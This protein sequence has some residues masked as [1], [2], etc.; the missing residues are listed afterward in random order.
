MTDHVETNTHVLHVSHLLTADAVFPH[1]GAKCAGV[2]T[3][4]YRRPVFTLD[5]PTG[6]LQHLEDVSVF[7]LGK[8]FDVLHCQFPC[9]REGI[10]PVQYL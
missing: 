6:F 4:E 10:E 3:K 8:G 2:E 9:L 1:P 7:Q 5:S